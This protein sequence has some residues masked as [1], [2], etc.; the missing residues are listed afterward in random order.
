VA[1]QIPIGAEDQFKGVVDLVTMKARVWRDETLGAQFDDVEIPEDL[2][3]KAQS[4]REPDMGGGS[5]MSKRGDSIAQKDA[6]PVRR[7]D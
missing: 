3:E 2:R 1:I 4:Y 6:A 5:D 7:G